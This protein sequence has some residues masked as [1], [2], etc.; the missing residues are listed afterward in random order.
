MF[1][2]NTMT[3]QILSDEALEIDQIRLQFDEMVA[4]AESLKAQQAILTSMFMF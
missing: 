1:N 4:L 3:Y 2:L